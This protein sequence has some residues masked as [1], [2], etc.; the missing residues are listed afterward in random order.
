VHLEGG[1]SVTDEPMSVV[2]YEYAMPGDPVSPEQD[3][4]SRALREAGN[5]A[6]LG[7]NRWMSATP[8]QHAE[9]R[10][11]AEIREMEAAQER[12]KQRAINPVVPLSLEALLARM[13]DESGWTREY[14]EH[15]V[16]WY[17]K[18]G[19]D[20]DGW[21]YCNHARDLGLAG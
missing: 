20:I 17:C 11:L 12:A 18:C 21:S 1:L 3:A 19:D 14:A 7:M 16:Q 9:W 6:V 15:L 5:R 10:R 2:K 13:S 8:E 4:L